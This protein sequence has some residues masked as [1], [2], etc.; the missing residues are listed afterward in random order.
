M[1][2]PAVRQG[3]E[4]PEDP[5]GPLHWPERPSTTRLQKETNQFVLVANDGHVLLEAGI[6]PCFWMYAIRCV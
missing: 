6:P 3:N 4:D 1:I 5:N 2:A